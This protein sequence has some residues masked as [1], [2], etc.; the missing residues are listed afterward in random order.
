MSRLELNRPELRDP[1]QGVGCLSMA[2]DPFTSVKILQTADVDEVII[3]TVT[4]YFQTEA[5]GK[6]KGLYVHCVDLLVDI[7]SLKDGFLAKIIKI[8]IWRRHIPS[9]YARSIAPRNLALRISALSFAVSR[10]S[11][12]S[13]GSS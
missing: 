7:D 1:F 8:L 11:S 2:I 6:P 4:K 3:D 9:P 13:N 10:Y 12:A 5:F